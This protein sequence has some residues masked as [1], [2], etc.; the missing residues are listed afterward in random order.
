MMKLLR[1]IFPL[2]FVAHIVFGIYW[3][4]VFVG[5]I[6]LSFW[7]YTSKSKLLIK[8]RRLT[9]LVYPLV[10]IGAV[11][12]AIFLRL[13]VFGIYVIPS[14]S[15]ERTIFPGD[16]V[17]VN[18]LVYGPQAPKSVYEIPW[19]GVAYW[20]IKGK[21]ANIGE[22]TWK[23]Y[24]FEGYGKPKVNDVMVFNH[25]YDNDVYIKRCLATPGDTIQIISGKTFV[26]SK[27]VTDASGVIFYSQTVF[28]ENLIA[29]SLIDSLNLN[30]YRTK[31]PL[32][33]DGHLTQRQM[34]YLTSLPGVVSSSINP[35]RPDTA[36]IVF[37]L[38]D[39]FN[40][41]IDDFGPYVLPHKG[42]TIELTDSAKILYGRVITELENQSL[43]SSHYTFTNNYFF[44]MGDNRHDSGDSRYFGPVP[45]NAIT[46]KASFIMYR[47]KSSKSFIGRWFLSFNQ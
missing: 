10:I 44:M 1:F 20:L 7:V 13:F 29:S 22:A 42:M 28:N 4:A 39:S 15:M 47:E 16:V 34:D 41:N 17:W 46:G 6:W 9:Y 30:I 43:D 31:N 21:P 3:M 36:F 37:P 26:N 45:E 32:A 24:R 23:N 11:F 18:K 40:W 8:F 5:L 35:M 38:H 12:L 27:L 2:V 14:S 19:L 25:P 33:Y